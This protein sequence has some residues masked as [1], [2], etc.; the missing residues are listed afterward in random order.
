MTAHT[1]CMPWCTGTT[2]RSQSRMLSLA[3]PAVFSFLGIVQRRTCEG[4]QEERRGCS[5]WLGGPRW[6]GC[7]RSSGV[8]QEHA[9]GRWPLLQHPPRCSRTARSPC[10]ACCRRR[11]RRSGSVDPGPAGRRKGG[12]R[13]RHVGEAAA[14]RPCHK[15]A[16]TCSAHAAI[17]LRSLVHGTHDRQRRAMPCPLLAA[18]WR[19]PAAAGRQPAGSRTAWRSVHKT[20][21]S[22]PAAAAPRL[23]PAA[24][25]RRG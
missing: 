24:G 21:R 10:T 25:R 14:R 22:A 1:Q 5:T 13:R 12:G 3:C 9:W 6:E 19:T 4:G 17:P 7:G 23:V 20:Q 18:V 2:M 16:V 15:H 8:C 11:W